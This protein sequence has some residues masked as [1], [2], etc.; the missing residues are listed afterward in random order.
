MAI[1]GTRTL[2]NS[3]VSEYG[4]VMGTVGYMSP[5]QA[6]GGEVDFRSDQF[7]LGRCSTK[8]SPGFLRSE[9]DPCGDDRRD[10]SR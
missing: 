7:S 2:R 10:P 1:P 6:T 9:K 5:E 4:T 8:W 3:T